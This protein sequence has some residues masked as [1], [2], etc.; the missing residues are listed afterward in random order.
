MTQI[1]LRPYQARLRDYLDEGGQR[2][3]LVAHR[4]SGKDTS[5]LVCTYRLAC[6]RVGTF[7]YMAPTHSQI[8]KIVWNAVFGNGQRL[9][10]V[11]FPLGGQVK[12]GQRWTG[13]NRPMARARDQVRFYPAVASG[14][15]V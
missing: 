12:S 3:V 8:K 2:A 7:F 1:Q 11:V 13:Q 4:R 10:D 9:I 14:C 5:A 15:N 6:Q